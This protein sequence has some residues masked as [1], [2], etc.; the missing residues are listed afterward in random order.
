MFSTIL[1]Y[2]LAGVVL[3][4]S[5]FFIMRKN[6]EYRQLAKEEEK[7]VKQIYK[8]EEDR[9]Y[10]LYELEKLKNEKGYSPNMEKIMVL[11][12]EEEAK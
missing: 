4:G 3:V 8:A 5:G 1:K 6:I 9:R 2:L 12:D 11:S 10:Y 7:L